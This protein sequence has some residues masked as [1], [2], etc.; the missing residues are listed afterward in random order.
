MR[1]LRSAPLL[2]PHTFCA[3]CV[4][5]LPACDRSPSFL[6]A[7]T[8]RP[9]RFPAESTRCKVGRSCKNL[10]GE[11]FLLPLGLR[12][13]H[14][15]DRVEVCSKWWGGAGASVCGRP[16]QNSLCNHI[17]TQHAFFGGGSPPICPSISAES[18]A[19]RAAASSASN[20]CP[21]FDQI[22]AIAKGT[23]EMMTDERRREWWS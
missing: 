15:P 6:T 22:K 13:F 12:G 20:A 14:G 3:M 21:V 5:C 18:A 10:S 11:R 2:L 9:R 7:S 16:K 19:G 8:A 4:L 1:E 17:T 23:R